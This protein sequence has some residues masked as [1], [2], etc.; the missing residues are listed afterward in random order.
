LDIRQLQGCQVLCTEKD[1]V[2]LWKYW[3]QA[4]AV[5]LIQ[6]LEPAFLA[7]LDTLLAQTLAAKLSSSH[8]HQT[9]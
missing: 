5:P 6:T 4:L 9:A 3:P 2:K 8:G 7:A 1:A